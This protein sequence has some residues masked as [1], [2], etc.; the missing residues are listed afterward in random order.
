MGP[1]QRGLDPHESRPSVRP[2]GTPKVRSEPP[3]VDVGGRTRPRR[4]RFLSGLDP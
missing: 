1:V 3:W 2:G 4:F